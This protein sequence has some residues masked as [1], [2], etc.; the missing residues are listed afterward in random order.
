MTISYLGHSSFK[1]KGKKGTLV[2]DPYHEYVGFKFP[3]TGADIVTVS[4]DH[5]DHNAVELVTGTARRKNPFVI[6]EAGEYEVGGIS[7]FGT[8]TYHDDQQGSL[9]GRNLVFTS[10]VDHVSVCHLGD[11]GHDLTPAQIE[12][13]GSVDVLLVPVGGVYTIDPKLATK[14]IHTL[15]PAYAVPMHY[16]TPA[17]DAK[18]FGELAT[19]ADFIKE[20]GAEPQVLPKLELDKTRLP[21][22]TELVVLTPPA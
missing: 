19:L 8:L 17:H 11:L 5:K 7:V 18:V 9:R 1:L 15:E 21:E 16:R 20:Y 22:E 13:I 4:H 12:A 3:G 14:I 6:N 2:T 10:L